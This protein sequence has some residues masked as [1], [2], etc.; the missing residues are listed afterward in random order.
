MFNIPF[1]YSNKSQAQT[2]EE[3]E[4]ENTSWGAEAELST[5]THKALSTVS[6]RMDGWMEW[7]NQSQRSCEKCH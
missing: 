4:H 6:E 5:L 7:Y 1:G 3:W 2:S